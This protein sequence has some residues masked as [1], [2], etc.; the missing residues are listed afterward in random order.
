MASRTVFKTQLTDNDTT[1]RDVL[2]SLREENDKIYKYVLFDG[3]VVAGDVVKYDNLTDYLAN[4]V[5]PSTSE[6]EVVAGVVMAT[7][8]ADNEYGWIQVRGLSDAL[9]VN[10]T[11]TTPAVNDLIAGSATTKAFKLY[12]DNDTAMCGVIADLTA[13]ANRVHLMCPL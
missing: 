10:I 1:A 8:A 6:V 12:V 2:G 5:G 9:S 4:D 13:S 11:G 3:A 7:S